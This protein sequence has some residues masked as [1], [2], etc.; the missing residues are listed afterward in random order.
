MGKLQREILHVEAHIKRRHSIETSIDAKAKIVALMR[1][2]EA[3]KVKGPSHVNQV[4]Q[5]FAFSYLNC[6]VLNH[7][8]EEYP[9]LEHPLVQN[10]DQINAIFQR[11]MNDPY[12]STYNLG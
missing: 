8:L 9:L 6:Q 3:L 1:R 11:V 7:V 12:A 4:N 5:I 2:I 10:Q